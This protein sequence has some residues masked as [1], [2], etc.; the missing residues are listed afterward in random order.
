MKD[1]IKIVVS[2]KTGSGK[3]RIS[4]LLKQFLE[5]NG[6]DVNLELNDGDIENELSSN[7]MDVISKLSERAQINISEVNIPR[8]TLKPKF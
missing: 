7:L 4:V 8:K 1:E 3:S 6:F 5:A 2:G